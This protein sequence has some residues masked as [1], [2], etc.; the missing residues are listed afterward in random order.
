MENSGW[1]ITLLIAALGL[2]G[3]LVPAWLSTRATNKRL[4]EEEASRDSEAASKLITSAVA[5]SD[6]TARQIDRN[7]KEIERLKQAHKKQITQLAEET[8]RLSAYVRNLL[9][10]IR[11][12]TEQL[13]EAQIGPKYKPP[14]LE[15]F[16]ATTD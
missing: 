2:L 16:T 10:G 13:K 15:D 4:M 9:E 7:T 6:A 5:L 14:L 8:Q 3:T 11:M 1:V 12:L